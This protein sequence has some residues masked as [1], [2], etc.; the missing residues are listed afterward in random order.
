MESEEVKEKIIAKL[1][2]LKIV[3]VMLVIFAVLWPVN[4]NLAFVLSIYTGLLI[5]FIYSVFDILMTNKKGNEVSVSSVLIVMVYLFLLLIPT[6][7]LY[8]DLPDFF[9]NNW[10]V[11]EGQIESTYHYRGYLDVYI[12]DKSISFW[13]P[14]VRSTDFPD[15][16]TMKIY[17]LPRSKYGVGFESIEERTNGS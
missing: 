7:K 16:S 13:D 17:Y 1:K 14:T 15:D 2:T 4:R 12:N 9:N 8:S 11:E 3:F 10:S 5:V 6:V